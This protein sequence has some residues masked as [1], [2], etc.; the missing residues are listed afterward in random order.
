MSALG[1]REGVFVWTN[2]K[3]QRLIDLRAEGLSYGKI[4]EVFGVSRDT[5]AGKCFRLK[6]RGVPA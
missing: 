2:K 6:A 3:E 5:I 4:A 1:S